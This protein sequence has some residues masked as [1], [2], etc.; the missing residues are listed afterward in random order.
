MPV[1]EKIIGLASDPS[2][3]YDAAQIRAKALL[4]E[5][6]GEIPDYKW[7]YVAGTVIRNITGALFGLESIS[8]TDSSKIAQLGV[9]ARQIALIWESLSKLQEGTK[10]ST[11]LMNAAVAYEL[12][13]YQANAACLAKQI[14]VSNDETKPPSVEEL[15]SVF[16][17]RLFLKEIMLC[18]SAKKEPSLDAPSTDVL[19]NI[20]VAIASDGFAS[21]SKY[22]LNGDENSLANAVASFTDAENCFASLGTIQEANLLRH[23]RSL[24]PIICMRSTWTVLGNQ[25]SGDLR[26]RRYLKLLARGVGKNLLECSSVSELWPSQISALNHNLLGSEASTVVKM[27]TS[28]G[29]TRVA[30]LAIVHTLITKPGSKCVYIAPYRALV[31]ELEQSFLNL[32]GDLGFSVSSVLGTYETDDFQELLTTDADILVMTPERL[33]LLQRAQPEFLKNVRLFVL[34]EGQIVQDISRGVK[35]ELLLTRLKRRLPNVRFLFLSAVVPQETLNDFAVWFN[36]DPN[37]DIITSEWRP[38]IQRVAEFEW[39]NEKGT[40]RYSNLEDIAIL[41][42][43]VSGV[44]KQQQYRFLNQ[45][46]GRINTKIFPDSTNKSQTAAEL[47]FRF[48]EQGSVLVFCS[49]PKWVK[50]VADA[51]N[52][53]LEYTK[54]IGEQVPSYFSDHSLT[55]SV[56]YAK[57]WLGNDHKITEFLKN[58]IAVHHGAL[59]DVLK[60]AIE[61]DFRDRQFR[62]LIATNTLAQGVNLPIRTVIVH[63]CWV[64]RDEMM[65]PIPARDYWNIAGRAGRAGRET[66]GTIIHIVMSPT[67][68][69]IFQEYLA[70]R[71]KVEYVESALLKLLVDVMYE[72]I[73]PEAL[74]SRL[75]PE[76]LALLVEE[77]ADSLSDDMIQ[78]IL[79]QT[80]FLMQANRMGFDPALIKKAFQ[81][82]AE[83]IKRRIPDTSYWPIYS[84]TGLK[85]NSCE[86][87]R[88]FINTNREKIQT[89]LTQAD[90]SKLDEMVSI[91]WEACLLVEEMQSKEAFSGSYLELLTT[92]LKGTDIND[93]IKQFEGQANSTADLAN[94]IED[95]FIFRLPWGISAF[96]RIA[97]K[98][99]D[100]SGKLS[101]Y[102]KF[103]PTMVKFGVPSPVASWAI[104]SGITMR[105]NAVE[106]ALKYLQSSNC[107][108]FKEFNE[109]FKNLDNEDFQREFGLQGY[110]LEDANNAITQSSGNALLKRAASIEQILPFLT[111]IKGITTEDAITI[112][113]TAKEGQIID[114]SRDYDS[115]Y[116]HNAVL[117][118]FNGR[119]LGYLQR[120]VAQLIAPDID[121]GLILKGKISSINLA[122]KPPQVIIRIDKVQKS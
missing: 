53:R 22:M 24:L 28:A 25:V 80:L 19:N 89:L 17:Q 55:R 85:S 47:A 106:I 36:A 82:T 67:D 97:E 113:S 92:W 20:A 120:D 102:A 10:R 114:L 107:P 108:N 103:F 34:D 9:S 13:G 62:V 104:T 5:I 49:N 11:A 88:N 15:S 95:L 115:I 93:I 4:K 116:D 57:A 3:Q 38:S 35:F 86:N 40:I 23:V 48:A 75:D 79:S 65:V 76:T 61:Q 112:A 54:L 71:D 105:K 8:Y 26:W 37:R 16:L 109:W 77:K 60:T 73:T 99:L 2:F 30:E 42:E 70:L 117:V 83:D 87:L 14:T 7:K 94:L 63:S 100:L 118:Q 6:T 78:D 101:D 27:P 45:M 29:K 18:K 56:T 31:Y 44:I 41:Q 64:K 96:L 59:P 12:A 1:T 51:L 98:E 81:G 69:R 43:F 72:R 21:A 39:Q 122:I 111:N 32:F 66:E 68:A 74:A 84:S 121:C 46:T 50:A 119:N 52:T 91:F 110:M 33:D 58:G 90:D